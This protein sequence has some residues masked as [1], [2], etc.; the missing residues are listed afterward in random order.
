MPEN[1]NSTPRAFPVQVLRLGNANVSPFFNPL[2]FRFTAAAQYDN[3][4]IRVKTGSSEPIIA[5]WLDALDSSAQREV[6][7]F[8]VRID[9]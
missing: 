7:D 4:Q 8:N 9:Q 1:S 2:V 5:P 3:T 6:R